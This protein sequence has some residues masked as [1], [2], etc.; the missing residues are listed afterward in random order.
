MKKVLIGIAAGA[1]LTLSANAAL[2]DG[3]GYGSVKDGPVVAPQVNWNGLYIGAAVGYG[4]ATTDLSGYSDT[5]E[6]KEWGL[7]GSE[8][9]W[10][11]NFAGTAAKG[12]SGDGAQGTL[13]L[14]YDRQIHP[15]LLVGIFGDYTFGDLDNDHWLGG[16]SEHGKQY[17]FD[18]SWFEPAHLSTKIGNNWSIGGRIGLVRENTLWYAFAGYSQADF[19]WK[20]V[21]YFDGESF[22]GGSGSKTLK[23]Y[24]LGLGVEHQ[25]FQNVSLKLEYRYTNYDKVTFGSYYEEGKNYYHESE[26]RADPDVHSIRLGVNWKVDLFGGHHVTPAYD[27]LK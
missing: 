16:Y 1:A 27:S 22:G 3:Y 21:S 13:T 11:G 24:F 9:H 12:L 6:V 17:I 5:Y 15:G 2:A 10:H 25:L 20:L 7:Y 19:D 23:G 26:F 14:G 4:I 8:K 18:D